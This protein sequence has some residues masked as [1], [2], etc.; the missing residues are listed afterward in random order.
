MPDDKFTLGE[1]AGRLTSLE[2]KV[3]NGPGSVCGMLRDIDGKLDKIAVAQ[4][5]LKVKVAVISASAAM[6]AT[7]GVGFLFKFVL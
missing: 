1:I 6:I 2:K 3:S 5:T 4:A 7:A